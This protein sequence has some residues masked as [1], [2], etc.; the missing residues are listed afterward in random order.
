MAVSDRVERAIL[1]PTADTAVRR[2][3]E[4]AANAVR[5]LDRQERRRV[6]GRVLTGAESR[7]LLGDGFEILDLVA[8]YVEIRLSDGF[9]SADDYLILGSVDSTTHRFVVPENVDGRRFRLRVWDASEV[10]TD[11]ATNA[12]RVGFVVIGER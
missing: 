9:A 11:V 8:S 7:I 5:Y 1:T 10:N 2:L 12:L 3:Q 6:E 4:W